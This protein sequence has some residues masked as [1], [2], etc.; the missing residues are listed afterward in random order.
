[1]A[2][3]N[4]DRVEHIIVDGGSGDRTVPI[5]R[6][7]ARA[8]PYL[9][10]ISEPD[11]GQSDALNKGIEMARGEY[12]GILNADDFYEPGVLSRIAAIIKT[13]SEP[14]FIV[15]ACNVLTTGDQFAVRGG[16]PRQHP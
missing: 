3:Q 4:C 6:E 7:K 8:H 5:L 16:K 15:G 12:I 2:A 11:R 10:W 14:R 13:L 9:R 1:V